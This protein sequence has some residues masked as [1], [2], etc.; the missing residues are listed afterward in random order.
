[1]NPEDKTIFIGFGNMGSAIVKAIDK[2][3]ALNI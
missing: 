1:M 3:N 2:K